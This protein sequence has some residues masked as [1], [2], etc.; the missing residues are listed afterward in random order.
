MGVENRGV[1]INQE[2]YDAM[3]TAYR[4]DPGNHRAAAR[5][6]GADRR[7]VAKA[8]EKGFPEK[9]LQPIKDIIDL[10][11][12]AS[13]ARLAAARELELTTIAKAEADRVIE[14][15][16]LATVDA[17]SS[18][19]AEAK[20][21]RKARDNATILLETVEELLIGAS[22]LSLRLKENLKDLTVD[23]LTRTEV[24]EALKAVGS[25]AKQANETAKISMQMERV[26]LGT[27]EKTIGVN[28][29]MSQDEAVKELKLANQALQRA[30]ERGIVVDG[31]DLQNS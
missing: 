3:L 6:T 23:A 4:H 9:G 21:V 20:I 2:R 16:A 1:R 29:N 22:D 12:E 26:L 30:R 31:V 27:P 28:I 14:D 18:R 5:K 10:E 7:T 13:R 19:T 25:L 15:K 11:R 17:V 24:I 8:W